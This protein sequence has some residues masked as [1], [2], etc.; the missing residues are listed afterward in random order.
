MADD[1]APRTVRF[2]GTINTGH[3]LTILV[4]LLGFGSSMVDWRGQSSQAVRDIADLKGQVAAQAVTTREA[5]KESVARVEGAVV[6]LQTTAAAVPTLTERQRQL[7]TEIQRLQTRDAEIGRYL[8]ERRGV[9]DSKFSSIE[10]RL[11][12]GT[13]DRRELRGML[14]ALHRASAVNLPGARGMR[15]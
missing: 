2:D 6:A 15:Q 13:A 8:D 10:Q 9:L 1:P 11:T 12:E 14:D 7:E 3:V 4:L 5:I